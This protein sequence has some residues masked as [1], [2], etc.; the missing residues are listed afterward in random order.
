MLLRK[1]R[2]RNRELEHL[3]TY[4][5]YPS[6]DIIRAGR[7]DPSSSQDDLI[8]SDLRPPP[9]R[10]GASYQ[11]DAPY[12]DSYPRTVSQ[13]SMSERPYSYSPQQQIYSRPE[14]LSHGAHAPQQAAPIVATFAPPLPPLASIN[15][16][17]PVAD[18]FSTVPLAFANSTYSG[19]YMPT[20]AAYNNPPYDNAPSV[21]DRLSA[22][23]PL[24]PPASPPRQKAGPRHVARQESKE[25]GRDEESPYAFLSHMID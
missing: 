7:I 5:A 15:G 23:L 2:Q 16:A 12:R 4:T 8:S 1:R 9:F 21:S 19:A 3:G 6:D 25:V 14:T 18:Q 20:S 24:P 11:S 22:P 10:Y 17:Y 13:P